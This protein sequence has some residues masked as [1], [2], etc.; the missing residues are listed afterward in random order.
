MKAGR[1]REKLYFKWKANKKG[2][3]QKEG[4]ENEK[5]RE[6][7]KEIITKGNKTSEKDWKIMK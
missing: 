6:K 7:N 2:E 1:I 5:K 4:R 3:R